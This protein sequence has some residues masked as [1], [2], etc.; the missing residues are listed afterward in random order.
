MT[1]NKFCCQEL[2]DAWGKVVHPEANSKQVRLIAVTPDPNRTF[3]IVEIQFCPW[4]ASRLA[5]VDQHV[6]IVQQA[7]TGV[8]WECD[9]RHFPSGWEQPCPFSK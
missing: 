1:D 4:C 5:T 7:N 8:C 3:A 9:K 2:Q 6:H